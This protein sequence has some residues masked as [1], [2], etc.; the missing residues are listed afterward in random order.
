[1]PL[2][3]PSEA[4]LKAC[5]AEAR[6]KAGKDKLLENNY[7]FQALYHETNGLYPRRGPSQWDGGVRF[8]RFLTRRQ[9]VESF[10]TI[11]PKAAP[12]TLLKLNQPQRKLECQVLRMERARV[13]VRINILKARQ[14]GFSTEASAIALENILRGESERSLIIADVQKRAE[15]IFGMTHTALA[16]VPKWGSE[17]FAFKLD[18]Q[19]KGAVAWAAPILGDMEVTSAG[20]EAAGRGGTRRFLHITETA[21]WTVPPDRSVGVLDSLPDELGT[22][23]LN[24]STANGDQGWFA[25]EWRAGWRERDKPFIERMASWSSIFSAWWEH[26]GYRWS[27][28]FGGGRPLPKSL[29]DTIESTLT[30]EEKWLLEQ[31]YIR[32]WTPQDEWEKVRRKK[33]GGGYVE[34][35]RRVGV[36]WRNV[37]FDQLAWRRKKIANYRGKGGEQTFNQEHPSRPDVAF[38]AS[39]S[40]VFDP[41]LV[42][43]LARKVRPPIWRGTIVLADE[44]QAPSLPALDELDGGI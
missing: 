17:R 2:W 26:D 5:R 31:R 16:A 3:Q 13:P 40:R 18:S 35:W 1:M 7:L 14:Q 21:F 20:Q 27:K 9:W 12:K 11:K 33:K 43:E 44:A 4:E 38:L 6:K 36:G 42:Q 28:T 8:R 32:R 15:M 39:G 37:D 30:E 23:G 25:N 34:V 24:E 19:A 10:Y 22:I 41:S 29:K